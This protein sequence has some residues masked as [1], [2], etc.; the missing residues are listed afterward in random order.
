MSVA[1][2]H[3][4]ALDHAASTSEVLYGHLLVMN[5]HYYGM[6]IPDSDPW[7]AKT[8]IYLALLLR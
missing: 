5:N 2:L 6:E 8:P 7:H 1:S 3:T 4:A